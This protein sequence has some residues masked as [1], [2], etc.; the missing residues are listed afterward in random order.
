MTGSVPDEF[1]VIEVSVSDPG[2]MED[3]VTV[4]PI[5]AIGEGFPDGPERPD[6]EIP[7]GYSALVAVDESGE[8][9][10]YREAEGRLSGSAFSAEG[11]LWVI[12]SQLR[13][14]EPAP[15]GEVL[16]TIEGRS[17][18]AL[19]EGPAPRGE[20]VFVETDTFHHAVIELGNGNLVAL[21][22]ELVDIGGWDEDPCPDNG[23]E[24]DGTVG[25]I[26][27]VVVE[28]DPDTGAIAGQ[29]SL[30]DLLDPVNQ[31]GEVFCDAVP[32]PTWYPDR[33][34][35]GDWT[36]ANGLALDE[37]NGLLLVSARHIHSVVGI[38]FGDD[39]DHRG[40]LVW[41]F[42]PGLDFA[43]DDSP[44]AEWHY[45][46]HAPEVLADG[47]LILY[48]N[49]NNRPGTTQVDDDGVEPYTRAV[50]YDIDATAGTASRRWEYIPV[51]EDGAPI[52]ATFLGDA[53]IL[54]NANVLIGHGGI[55]VIEPVEVEGSDQPF[56]QGRN[57]A[58]ILEVDPSGDDR[59][60]VVFE[61]IIR[62][63]RTGWMSFEAERIASLYGWG[64]VR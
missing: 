16:R 49:G 51:D 54:T 29:W 60:D 15:T 28:F 20:A 7:P 42:G 18:R 64:K 32:F 13:I 53:D 58:R 22:T 35:A 17:S 12:E 47:G 23:V 41:Q 61:L 2:R 50:I 26:V 36:H 19:A 27:D 1:P 40:E 5:A 6:V 4:F 39:R 10:W 14:L 48:D 21:S 11:T 55:V 38:D 33:P 44:T 34:E 56:P 37:N 63:P 31:P 62:D 59:G 24:Y 52:Y 43:L 57:Y 45:M 8:V 9:I 30:L 46:Q 3:G 25:V